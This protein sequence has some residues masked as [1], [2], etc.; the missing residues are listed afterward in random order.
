MTSLYDKLGGQE[1]VSAAV[2][3]FYV[4]VLADGRINHFFQG[5][6]MEGQKAKGKAFIAMAFGGPNNY[7][8]KELREGHRHL[9][10]RGLNDAHFDVFAEHFRDTLQD[11]NVPENLATEVMAAVEGARPEILDR[12]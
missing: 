6:D 11:L 9:V 7:T 8:G 12:Y 2:E 10:A 1:A 4:K 3:H 5:I